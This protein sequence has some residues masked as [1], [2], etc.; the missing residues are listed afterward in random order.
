[1]SEPKVTLRVPVADDAH[2]TIV[3]PC[4]PNDGHGA[5][6]IQAWGDP[7]QI[8]HQVGSVLVGYDYLLS[9]SIT[10]EE[11]IRRLR[12]MRAARRDALAE[13]ETTDGR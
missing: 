1:M 7:T 12:L 4:P 11:A 9:G 2:M 5:A 10:T 8:R 3:H 6:W 13:R